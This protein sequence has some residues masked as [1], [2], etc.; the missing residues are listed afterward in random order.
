MLL[1]ADK[2]VARVDATGKHHA[3]TAAELLTFITDNIGTSEYTEATIADRDANIT[4]Q[5]LG[6]RVFVTDATADGDVNAGWA[7]YTW[8]GS[9]WVKVAE[10]EGLDVVIEQVNLTAVADATTVTI[11][12][13]SSGTSAVIGL[14]TATVAGLLS[15]AYSDKL[16]FITVTQA[17]DLDAMSGMAHKPAYADLIPAEN[18]IVVDPT[19][20]GISFDIGL[21]DA[22]P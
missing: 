5:S 4:G 8:D 14:A 2:F 22:L 20:Q 3:V 10:E 19:T 21:L 15:P 11:D 18:P 7:I 6:D 1:G 12:N 17:V 13:S 9:N 16:S